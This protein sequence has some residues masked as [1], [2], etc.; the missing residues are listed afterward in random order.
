VARPPAA[1]LALERTGGRVRLPY[2]IPN[3]DKLSS[4][5]AYQRRHRS[6]A[7]RDLHLRSDCKLESEYNVDP[8]R[9]YANGLSNVGGMSFTLS[10]KLSKRIAAIGG[11]AGAYLLPWDSFTRSRPVP[12]IIFHGNAD[13]IVP[14]AGGLSCSFDIPFPHID[15]WVQTLAEHK[16]CNQNAAVIYYTI[17]GGGHTWPGGDPLPEWITGA[18]S[19]DSDSTRLMWEFFQQHPLK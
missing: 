1:D 8:D 5:L 17:D 2:D 13:P 15:D 16:G 6:D 9:I 11:V 18:N 4:A 19:D 7:S 10:C 14:F 12:A 3:G